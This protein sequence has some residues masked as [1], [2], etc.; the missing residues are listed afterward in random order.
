MFMRYSIMNHVSELFGLAFTILFNV[1]PLFQ[2]VTIVRHKSSYNNSIAMWVCGAFGQLCMMGYY[3]SMNVQGM[4][5]YINCIIGLLLN[6]G[7]VGCI[8]YYSNRNN[9]R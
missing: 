3:V 5:N 2:L 1:A 6:L 7:M 9:N 8:V 4:F